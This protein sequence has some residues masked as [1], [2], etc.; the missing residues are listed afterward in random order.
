MAPQTNEEVEKIISELAASKP[1]IEFAIRISRTL[2][3]T[4][5]MPT[6]IVHMV[7]A[8]AS[9]LTAPETWLPDLCG[10][11]TFHIKVMDPSVDPS[12]GK[13]IGMIRRSVQAPALKAINVKLLEGENW[14]GPPQ[15][16][17]TF[18]AEVPTPSQETQPLHA[19]VRQPPPPTVP[20]APLPFGIDPQ[21]AAELTALRASMTALQDA[22]RL[23]QQSAADAQAALAREKE[24]QR[25][26]EETRQAEE[27]HK[28]DM[29]RVKKEAE[30][31]A[32]AVRAELAEVKQ[33]LKALASAP[34]PTPQGPT[35][36]DILLRQS[37][38]REK[39][40]A[41]QA[42]RDEDFR[43]WQAEREEK[44][45]A[46]VRETAEKAAAATE[47]LVE[48]LAGKSDSQMEGL[49]KMT[50]MMG[51]VMSTSMTAFQSALD[52]RRAMEPSEP[53]E[54]TAE[55]ISAVGDALSK[56]I[57]ALA[58]PKQQQAPGQQRQLP[59]GQ[60]QQQS[61]HEP[62]PQEVQDEIAALPGA[63]IDD[64]ELP[65]QKFLQP[66]IDHISSKAEPTQFVTKFFAELNS[67]FKP[68]HSIEH[69]RLR[70]I[71]AKAQTT[72]EIA[73]I[74]FAPYLAEWYLTDKPGAEAYLA[75]L[76]RAFTDEIE[77]RTKAEEAAERAATTPKARA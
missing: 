53:T 62:I 11:G 40:L 65:S 23:A 4:S 13:E 72:K 64:G 46:L 8:K 42:K 25:R 26:R 29:E 6:P 55:V 7:G 33:M 15:I 16:T 22:A 51:Q 60:E 70:R 75:K 34:A 68:P 3:N 28:I 66:F 10:G 45:A 48:K 49:T 5:M 54:S 52:M 27:R 17:W 14:R 31:A 77:I 50:Q 56:V 19:P 71:T 20:Q 47:K 38:S 18:N 74:L 57:P 37:E 30:A 59:P 76:D 21:T 41:A 61:P 67:H 2:P 44:Q 36:V 12:S 32:A 1:S 63:E 58:G 9:H 43:R 39:E 35:V 69:V 73:E 24:E